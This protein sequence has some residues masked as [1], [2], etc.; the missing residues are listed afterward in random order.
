MNKFNPKKLLLSKWTARQPKEKEKHFIVVKIEFD[1][2]KTD[3]LSCTLEALMTKKRYKT[4]P[5]ELQN[6]QAW[7]QGW[8]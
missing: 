6:N 7:L 1:E 4:Y 2:T 8:K 3:V 5:E